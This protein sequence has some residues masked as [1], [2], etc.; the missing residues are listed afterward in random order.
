VSIAEGGFQ[1]VDVLEQAA[2]TSAARAT[3]RGDADFTRD[4]VSPI[5][6]GDVKGRS[7]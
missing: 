1:A 5:A 3:A 7:G 2:V 6:P 4:L